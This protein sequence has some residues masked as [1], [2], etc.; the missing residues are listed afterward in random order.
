MSG[1]SL[2][3]SLVVA[4][5]RIAGTGGALRA[6]DPSTGATLEPVFDLAGV[7]QVDL[8]AAAADGAVDA[9]R[10]TEPRD[11]AALLEAIAS[12]LEHRAA[13]L[14]A[15]AGQ[16]TALPSERLEG[17]LARTTGQLRAFA[18]LLGDPAG[19]DLRIDRGG[20]GPDLRQRRIGIGPVAVFG[21]SNFPSRSRRPAATRPRPSPPAA[22]W[23]SSR[24]RRIRA[25]RR[26]R[27]KR[28]PRRCVRSGC[29]PAPS[30]R[31]SVRA[32]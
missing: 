27:R 9:L 1:G 28:S 29:R 13:S 10:A 22:R 20:D 21:A 12:G 23:W 14:I 25:P 19:A 15:R 26:S 4:G 11:R 16:E 7:E 8:A 2:D 6:I 30:R 3:G 5:R 32:R 18:A 24:T 17:E 31:C